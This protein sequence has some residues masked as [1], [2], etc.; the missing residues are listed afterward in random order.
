MRYYEVMKI[1]KA[2][3]A[4]AICVLG[5]V[6]TAH[7]LTQLEPAES[8]SVEIELL[9]LEANN[10][11]YGYALPASGGSCPQICTTSGKITSCY[12]PSTCYTQGYYQSQYYSQSQYNAQSQY[13]SQGAY[14]TVPIPSI[15]IDTDKELVRSGDTVE[16]AWDSN[17]WNGTCQL[18]PSVYFADADVAPNDSNVSG[19][20]D[21]PVSAKT[22]FTYRCT[23]SAGEY[24]ASAIERASSVQV[25]I[26]PTF[27]EI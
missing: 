4:F 23:S 7:T 11:E 24:A 21:I 8:K 2:L 20:V 22:T 15:T 3:A 9:A 12:I 18:F 1:L 26:I 5:F 14:Y 25:E 13:Y 27:Q 6:I 19:S 10:D 16:I 17:G